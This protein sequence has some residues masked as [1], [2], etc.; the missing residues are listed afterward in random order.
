MKNRTFIFGLIATLAATASAL[1]VPRTSEATINASPLQRGE[2][3]YI[4]D[5]DA[6]TAYIGTDA[7]P[8]RVS[9]PSTLRGSR[10]VDV[11][12]G[13]FTVVPDSNWT[14]TSNGWT[15]ASQNVTARLVV[16]SVDGGD[17]A[18]VGYKVDAISTGLFAADLDVQ[19]TYNGATVI[20]DCKLT[21]V[22]ASATI[23][24]ITPTR[25]A[26][27]DR[28]I[29]N[30]LAANRFTLTDKLGTFD[31]YDLR[32]WT[33]DLYNGNRGEDWAAYKAKKRVNLAGNALRF[34][35][36][37]HYFARMNA[38][39]NLAVVV[40]GAG[41]MEFTTGRG[42]IATGTLAITNVNAKGLP[43]LI[44]GYTADIQD[45]NPAL[46]RVQRRG[47]L[48]EDEWEFMD[49]ARYTATAD[50][51]TISGCGE[52]HEFYRLWYNGLETSAFEVVF[53]ASVRLESALYLR[54]EDNVLYKITVNA[55]VISATAQTE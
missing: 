27:G 36:D 15:L 20:L 19:F 55:G 13:K 6:A 32:R 3:A 5:G 50:T 37:G 2:F 18:D 30:D 54:G 44:V 52:K 9:D 38:H 45:F 17:I 21:D 22:T 35:D 34:D 43:V 16:T 28:D 23:Y 40:D 14:A 53:R 24:N 49:P 25:R 8:L 26:F 29:V 48:C 11:P 7:G 1:T 47:D 41:V 33:R 39:T 42:T 31:L 4:V 10:L 46:L 51:V 12:V